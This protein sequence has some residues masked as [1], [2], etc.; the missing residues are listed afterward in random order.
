MEEK[1][2]ILV[3]G[4]SGFVSKS[5]AV[6]ACAQGH[7][8]WTVTR[9]IRDLPAGV[10]P[11]I[12]D[13]HDAASFKKVIEG[14]GVYWD[15]VYDCICYTPEDARQDI[16]VLECLTPRLIWISTDNVYETSQR[17]FPQTEENM[18]F[19]TDDSYGAKKRFAELEFEKANQ[20]TLKW[21]AFRTPHIYGPGSLLGCLPKH[22]R[23][24]ALIPKIKR[25]EA[26]QLVGGG[27]FLQQPLFIDD[28]TDLMLDSVYNQKMFNEIY[29]VMGPDIIESQQYYKII[30]EYLGTDLKIE[31][32]PVGLYLSE[33][34]DS[35]ASLC[36]RI[37][38]LSKLRNT[39]AKMPSTTIRKGLSAHVQ[40]LL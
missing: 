20:E 7:E 30:A 1:L 25:G 4:G 40:S 32:I 12:V 34:P 39:G 14:A 8:V 15:V 13:R 27:H 16:D 17:W 29:C 2:K 31:E 21:T 11:L 28:L 6:K 3:I 22:M 37:Y 19:L 26:L 10:H 36:H 18:N 9:G 35:K 38:D 24:A 23:D 33:F 5:L